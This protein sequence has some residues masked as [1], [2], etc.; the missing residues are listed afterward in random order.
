ML[1]NYISGITIYYMYFASQ[2][3]R[4]LFSLAKNDGLEDAGNESTKSHSHS[5][6]HLYAEGFFNVYL[7][8]DS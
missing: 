1:F 2:C 7:I 6:E 3:D 8:D 5:G 4:M